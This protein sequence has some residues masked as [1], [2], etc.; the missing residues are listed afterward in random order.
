MKSLR[1]IHFASQPEDS[2]DAET[3]VQVCHRRVSS[4]PNFLRVAENIQ[5]IRIKFNQPPDLTEFEAR[6]ANELA[7]RYLLVPSALAGGFS[8]A[9]H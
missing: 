5:E 2:S 9:H 3:Y 6:F 4:S 7:C 8:A 1:D